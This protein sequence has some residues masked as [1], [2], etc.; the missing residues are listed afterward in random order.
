[1]VAPPWPE[2]PLLATT[3]GDVWY[4]KGFPP[5]P[6]PFQISP[7]FDHA[8]FGPVGTRWVWN[9]NDVLDAITHVPQTQT[10]LRIAMQDLYD[11]LCFNRP[12]T[13]FFVWQVPADDG[14]AIDPL[15]Y[16][17]RWIH[18]TI[19]AKL[20]DVETMSHTLNFRTAPAPD[21]DQAE[22]DIATFAGQVRDIWQT[23]FKTYSGAH[24]G[25]MAALVGN[26][27]TYTDVT[28]AY[29]EQNAPAEISLHP[30]RKTAGQV[31]EFSYPRPTYLVPT[32]FATFAPGCTGTD[33]GPK[34]PYEVAMCASFTTGLRGPRNRGRLYFGGLPQSVMGSDGSFATGVPTNVADLTAHLVNLLNTGTGA[35]LHVVSRTYA[36]S[37]GVNGVTVGAIPDSQRRRR[38]S[39]KENFGSPIAT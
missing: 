26:H 33:T 7:P 2:H 27:V 30:S 38:R 35:R 16:G 23:W 4:V 28:A 24:G 8:K 21:V 1:M 29:L 19:N 34:L 6:Y 14:A 9:G 11:K 20:G 5:A 32:Q 39:L 17:M 15:E 3:L 12:P 25:P 22:Q 13:Q 36:T 10:F 31:K 37:V 18:V